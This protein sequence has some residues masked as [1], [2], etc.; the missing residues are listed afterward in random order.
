MGI[1]INPGEKIGIVCCSNGWEKR[2]DAKVWRLEE[3][4]LGMRLVP[5]FSPYIFIP[6]LSFLSCIMYISN[7]ETLL[8][9]TLIAQIV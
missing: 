2:K 1:K 7:C 4:L 8:R 6:I 9:V 3:V 5:V